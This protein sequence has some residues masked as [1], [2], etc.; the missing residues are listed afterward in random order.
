MIRLQGS[1]ALLAPEEAEAHGQRG[2]DTNLQGP[3]RGVRLPRVHVRADVFSENRPGT[4]GVSAIAEEHQAHGGKHPRA[5]RP[6]G[7]MARDHRVGEEV[8]PHAA[9]LG[10][11][12]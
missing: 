5:D 12:L 8:E 4:P 3:G 1:R 6:I 2:D 11:L 10:E 7:L 9:R